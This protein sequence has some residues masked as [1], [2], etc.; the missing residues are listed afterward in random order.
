MTSKSIASIQEIAMKA[1]I[2]R[3][4]PANASFQRGAFG[5]ANCDRLSSHASE[6]KRTFKVRFGWGS[7]E[8][9]D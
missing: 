4:P 2:S 8:T 1:G 7:P 9:G 5:F 6:M 3:S